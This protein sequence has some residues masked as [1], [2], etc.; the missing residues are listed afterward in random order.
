MSE[1][2]EHHMTASQ[3]ITQ[4]DHRRG[5]VPTPEGALPSPRRRRRGMLNLAAWDNHVAAMNA[6]NGT[7]S[8]SGKIDLLQ[9]IKDTATKEAEELLEQAGK[10]PPQ[11]ATPPP[12]PIDPDDDS[13]L[14]EGTNKRPAATSAGAL[15][16]DG[17]AKPSRPAISLPEPDP[18]ALAKAKAALAAESKEAKSE[19]TEGKIPPPP[20]DKKTKPATPIK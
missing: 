18:A 15:L 1:P 11:A 6:A 8:T 4:N 3:F 2:T 5:A 12:R 13:K 10:R 20:A 19:G 17:Q 7:T 14:P 16:E 9:T